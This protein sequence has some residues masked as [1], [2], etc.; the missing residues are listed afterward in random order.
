MDRNEALSLLG[1]GTAAT[2]DE[3]KA[4]AIRLLNELHPDKHPEVA[5]NSTLK[6]L[7]EEKFSRVVEARDYLLNCPEEGGGTG[8][9]HTPDRPPPPAD[10]IDQVCKSLGLDVEKFKD[11]LA[12]LRSSSERMSGGWLS[13]EAEER[14]FEADFPGLIGRVHQTEIVGQLVRRVKLELLKT[15]ETR[16]DYQHQALLILESEEVLPFIPELPLAGLCLAH[17]ALGNP[18]GKRLPDDEPRLVAVWERAKEHDEL[19]IAVGDA[20]MLAMMP[21]LP[22]II[23][24]L[25]RR[26]EA[27]NIELR[28]EPWN[29]LLTTFMRRL[30]GLAFWT[31]LKLLPKRGKNSAA[32]DGCPQCGSTKLYSH[33]ECVSCGWKPKKKKKKN[34]AMQPPD[35][36]EITSDGQQT[37]SNELESANE[38]RPTGVLGSAE[39]VLNAGC[40]GWVAV[41]GVIGGVAL[42]CTGV[43]IIHGFFLARG[44]TYYLQSYLS[45]SNERSEVTDFGLVFGGMCL[46][47]GI[48]ICATWAV[49]AFLTSK[50]H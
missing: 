24:P 13:P 11:G 3:V 49:I 23:A 28:S 43:G 12:M 19:L 1:L 25:N 16:P 40:L 26:A 42:M 21:R 18:R 8:W 31:A 36:V 41:F 15:L 14:A 46:W 6:G 33:G 39:Q 9:S 30:A 4:R 20:I 7:L 5:A 2:R 44:S 22:A 29:T 10:E 34:D 48:A 38:S 32:K 17:H 47:V 37:S 27:L 35:A 50:A 45:D